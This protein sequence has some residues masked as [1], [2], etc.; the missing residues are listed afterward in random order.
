[1]LFR[2]GYEELE[3]KLTIDSRSCGVSTTNPRVK[4]FSFVYDIS[5]EL[6]TVPNE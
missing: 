1:M 2:V 4:L 5:M 3:W 6:L